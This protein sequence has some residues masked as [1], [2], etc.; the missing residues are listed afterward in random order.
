VSVVAYEHWSGRSGDLDDKFGRVYERKYLVLSDL[1]TNQVAVL[2]AAGLPAVWSAFPADPF[3][4]AVSRHAEPDPEDPLRWWVVVRYST[5]VHPQPTESPGA[6]L[7]GGPPQGT[8]SSGSQNPLNRPIRIRWYTEKWQKPIEREVSDA[9]VSA[10]QNWIRNAAGD[11]FLPP[12]TVDRSR[13]VIEIHKNEATFDHDK[14]EAYLDSVNKEEFL[15]YGVK[16][17]KFS[18]CSTDGPQLESGV[19]F[20][21]STYKF[22][23]DKNGWLIRL[24]NAGVRKLVGGAIAHVMVNGIPVSRPVPLAANGDVLAVGANPVELTFQ[25]YGVTDFD[26]L[27][28]F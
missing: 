3:A 17:V 15:G 23:V 6:G 14:V 20:W 4:L 22:H 2:G 5:R 18:E 28:L 19:I 12:V 13:F 21:Q 8:D 11:P 24:L 10:G 16:K 27:G 1:P 26:D 9:G 7:P 25:G